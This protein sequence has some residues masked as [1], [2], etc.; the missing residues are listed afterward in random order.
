MYQMFSSHFSDRP[1]IVCHLA[2]MTRQPLQPVLIHTGHEVPP[3]D[4]TL[5]HR[6]VHC[7][8][9]LLSFIVRASVR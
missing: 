7:G 6:L 2:V 9:C 3:P 5:T 1:I 8:F 4:L